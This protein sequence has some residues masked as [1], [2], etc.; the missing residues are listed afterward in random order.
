MYSSDYPHWDFK[1]PSVIYDLDF[2]DEDEKLAI[3]GRNAQRLF[4]LD[5][6]DIGR[7]ELAREPGSRLGSL[8]NCTSIANRGSILLAQRPVT[9]MT[10]ATTQEHTSEELATLDTA[11]IVHPHQIVGQPLEPVVIARA[12][13]SRLWDTAGKE[14]IDGT[15]G[16]WQCAVGHGRAELGD[17][18]AK[19]TRELEFYASFWDYSNVP[20]I[21]LAA[22]LSSLT[23]DSL[24]H[25]HFTSG[26]SEGTSTAI[27]LARL[28]WEQAG[29]P[30]K[31][32]I[33]S[34]HGAYHGSDAGA[35]LAAT[36]LPDLR[37]GF[38]PL[39]GGVEYLGTPSS[40]VG[41]ADTDEL[42]AE[43]EARIDALGADRVAA[44]IGEPV[45]GVGG[46][47][48]PPDDYWPRVQEVLRKNNILLVLDEV[49]TA[50]GRLGHWFAAELIGVVPDLLVTAKGITSGY[51]P[52]GAV[53]IG[54]RVMDLLDGVM[55]R[56][57]LTYN[58]HPVGA[59][60]ALENISIIEREGL[61]D[62]ARVLG[63]RLRDA[64]APLTNDPSV[65]EV[66]GI[67]MMAAVEFTEPI[68]PEVASGARERGA[69]V[70]GM[71]SRIIISPPLVIT[72]EEVDELCATIV[73]EVERR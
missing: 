3:L 15:C 14:Y 36:G 66:R 41:G 56:H 62:R 65:V 16:L 8:V 47:I 55:L 20:S 44:F 68:G 48:V 17:V 27:K 45:M 25:V 11:H 58:G 72:E 29:A 34:R 70:R 67:G 19:Q 51:F 30:T 24:S 37:E 40:G 35:A 59:A 49:V 23:E 42:V 13:G 38:D 31:D 22:L 4:G 21:E 52:F 18:A 2:L 6:A 64:L 9:A 61:L 71:H 39:P 73:A 60:V 28:A 63:T 10:T 54:D 50:F 69:I 57:G 26:G 1:L 32:I 53:L 33:L 7:P 46:V 43:L 5:P 12:S